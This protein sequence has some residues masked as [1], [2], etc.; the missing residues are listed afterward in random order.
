M[1]KVENG[2]FFMNKLSAKNI[3]LILIIAVEVLLLLVGIRRAV[4]TPE[5]VVFNSSNMVIVEGNELAEVDG[6]GLRIKGTEDGVVRLEAAMNVHSGAAF[7]ENIHYVANKSAEA[8]GNC[9]V[10]LYL[11]D[12][13]FN[14]LKQTTMALY[15]ISNEASGRVYADGSAKA[16]IMVEC[17]KGCDVVIES[18]SIEEK[19]V[20]Q[21]M[22]V[23]M[24][25]LFSLMLNLVIVKWD[26]ISGKLNRTNVLLGAIVVGAMIPTVMDYSIGGHDMWFHQQRVV[27][28]AKE[29]LNGNFP[30]RLYSYAYNGY[31]YGGPLFYGDLFLYPLAVM[32]NLMFSLDACFKLFIFLNTVLT[33]IT[34]YYLAKTV[35]S[36][37]KLGIVF[38]ML[39]VFSPYRILCIWIRSAVGEYSALAFLPLVALGMYLIYK[40]EKFRFRNAVILGVGMAGIFICHVLTMELTLIPL[41]LTAI[42]LWRKTF[43][44]EGIVSLATSIAVFIG[45]SAWFI[46]PFIHT[47]TKVGVKAFNSEVD[48]QIQ[49]TGAYLIQLLNPFYPA[50]G[51][52]AP[53]SMQNDIPLSLGAG[54][55]CGIILALYIAIDK[56]INNKKGQTDTGTHSIFMWLGL[57]SATMAT[58]YFPWNYIS[59]IGGTKIAKLVN[60][61]Q[62]SW[63]FLGGATLM[64]TLAFVIGLKDEAVA[65]RK[66]QRIAFIS[67]ACAVCAISALLFYND[68]YHET[69]AYRAYT[70]SDISSAY[71][72]TFFSID[73]DT[74]GTGADK[75]DVELS[76]RTAV[77]DN[78]A[79]EYK[80]LAF[81]V[82]DY[83]NVR[84]VN[85][86]DGKAMPSHMNEKG[87]ITLETPAGFSGSVRVEYKEPV[88]W[89]ISELVTIV[90][91][92]VVAF[93]MRKKEKADC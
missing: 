63:R 16:G 53:S 19:P 65:E 14:S 55:I 71:T 82:Y 36:D 25:V 38:T 29:L 72:D 13:K 73:A 45:M 59:R 54:A 67:S 39:Y 93:L 87:L 17:A 37:E 90:S 57:L 20:W 70:V 21:W 78:S 8:D 6:S 48:S 44:K 34:S 24:L 31:G 75:A 18:V 50:T 62:F 83:L 56:V 61:C 22:K 86:A 35:T 76:D 10:I 69:K 1:T 47:M 42:I 27:F 5:Q 15:D 64:L 30:V 43:S 12:E 88:S 51:G 58:V 9:K 32:Y 3:K 79:G 46:V 60:E 91:I 49:E 74:L 52:T 81:P 2:D 66:I 77:I 28:V 4:R 68:Y 89:R 7:E 11:D 92:I 80:D 41:V 84:L 85:E 33:A 26:Y 40:E 23:L